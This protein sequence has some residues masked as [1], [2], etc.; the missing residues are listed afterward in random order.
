[1]TQAQLNMLKNRVGKTVT[2]TCADGDILR[3]IV[4]YIDDEYHDV[5]C[6]LVSSNRPEKY[7]RG[8]CYAVK[9]ADILD[10]R[11]CAE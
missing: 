9:W 6:D 2:I 10:C 3:G 5:T 7:K 1:M 4:A 8:S 11:D